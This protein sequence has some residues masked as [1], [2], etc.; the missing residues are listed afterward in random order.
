M[1]TLAQSA[2]DSGIRML[3][4]GDEK[5]PA[6]FALSGAEYLDLTEQRDR[7]AFARLCPTRHYARK[8]VGYLFA[9][10]DGTEVIQE[11]DD[12]NA[13]L[14]DFFAPAVRR[15]PCRR[16]DAAGWIN[17]YRLFSGYG[18]WPRG[19]PLDAINA[20]QPAYDELQVETVDSPIQQGLADGD[21]DVDAVFRLVSPSE[22]HFA[23][24]RRVTLAKGCWCPFNSQNTLWFAEAF[25]LL[26]LPSYCS[27]RMTDIWRSFVAQRI[28][29]T[30]GW[31]VSFHSA[32]VRQDRNAHN[33]MRD[34]A[35]EIPGYLHNRI[36]ADRL[37]AL[38]LEQGV[39]ALGD[40][41]R[42][43]YRELVVMDLVGEKELPL[44]DAWLAELTTTA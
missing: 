15:Q 12:D 28:A 14:T 21:P 35:D 43:C 40:N 36:I 9:A 26:Y 39:A 17:V 8:N 10:A 1:R 34:F 5:T 22:V 24:G 11:T 44:L 41:L 25:P 42:R 31:E 2:T 27:F 29:W 33:L 13:P 18:V 23:P 37:Y 4:V 3:V 19:L 6:D 7:S 20:P 30:N 16:L 32:T 38:P